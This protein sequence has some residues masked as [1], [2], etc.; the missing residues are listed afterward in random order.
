MDEPASSLDPK[1]R[2]Q[3]ITLL[4]A[5]RHTKIIASHDLDLILDVCE[6][7]MVIQEGQVM[8]DGTT[9]NI[10]TDR[11]LLEANNL[12]LPLSMQRLTT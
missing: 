4:R 12:E 3:L 6:R 7:C 11:G 2:R 5:F 8:A 10:L 9:S 1:A